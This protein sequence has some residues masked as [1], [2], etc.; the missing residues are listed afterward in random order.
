VG[1]MKR[2]KRPKTQK[3]RK[4][5][6]QVPASARGTV[7]ERFLQVL[8]A[9]Y[10]PTRAAKIA[11]VSRSTAYE[12][13]KT[14]AAFDAAWIDADIQGVDPMTRCSNVRSMAAISC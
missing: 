4:R 11:G 8:A 10:S 14:D 1:R 9:G 12:W 13:R 2:F 3:K 7:K 5:K 6:K